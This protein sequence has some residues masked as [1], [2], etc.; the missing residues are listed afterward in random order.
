VMFLQ[1]L[2]SPKLQTAARF[3]DGGSTFVSKAPE[4]PKG[5]LNLG[6]SVSA[7]MFEGDFLFTGGYDMELR[8]SLINQ[9][10]S[11]KFRWLF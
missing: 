7:L 6:G 9:A 1:D 8:K 5:G 2:K 3:V 11:F 10:I 4:P